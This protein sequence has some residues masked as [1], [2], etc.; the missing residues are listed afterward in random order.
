VLAGLTRPG[1]TERWPFLVEAVAVSRSRHFLALAALFVPGTTLAADPP[2]VDRYGDPIPVGAIARLGTIDRAPPSTN[3]GL[4]F[5]ADG[6]TF[7]AA[8][9][10]PAWAEWDA[11]TGKLLRRVRLPGIPGSWPWVSADGSVAVCER[12]GGIHRVVDIKTGKARFDLPK[13]A[14]FKHVTDPFSPDGRWLAGFDQPHDRKTPQHVRV[15]D[16]AT[17]KERDFGGQDEV[18]AEVRFS[19]DGSKLVAHGFGGATC[20]EVATGKQLW[21]RKPYALHDAPVRF[22]PDG[23]RVR[24]QRHT[25]HGGN[26]ETWDVATGRPADGVKPL[27]WHLWVI[28]YA[29]GGKVAFAGSQEGGQRTCGLWDLD[30]ERWLVRHPDVYLG[31]AGI[32]PDGKSFLTTYPRLQRWDVETLKP[33]YP[34]LADRGHL[35]V[36]THALYSPD[37]RRVYTAGA[38]DGVRAWEVPGGRP[39]WAAGPKKN[40]YS[41]LPRLA[42]SPDGS[43]LVLDHPNDRA[44]GASFHLIDPA[45]GRVERVVPYPNQAGTER[46]W[47]DRF[48]TPR[49][50]PGGTVRAAR[51]YLVRAPGR[52]VMDTAH[53][54]RDWDAAAGRLVRTN[55][56]QFTPQTTFV[57]DLAPD[58]RLVCS[59]R[60][61]CDAGTGRVMATLVGPG[62][63][64]A[65]GGA[66][67]AD[68][69]FV[70]VWM[71][72][73]DLP[74]S[75]PRPTAAAAW[76]WDTLT[77]RPVAKVR[78]GGELMRLTPDG[79][80]LLTANATG[81][82]A[83]DLVT[84]TQVVHHPSDPAGGYFEGNGHTYWIEPAPDGRTAVTARADQTCLVWDFSAAYRQAVTP[85]PADAD[86]EAAWASWAKP[87]ANPLAGLWRLADHPDR[88]VPF[89]KAKV[90]GLVKPTPGPT[91]DDIRRAVSELDADEFKTREAAERRLVEYGGPA[92]PVAAAALPKASPEARTR[93]GRV[94]AKLDAEPVPP[95]RPEDVPLAWAVAVLERVNSADARAVI[96]QVAAGPPGSRLT[97]EAN[98]ALDRVRE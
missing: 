9:Y 27:P 69:R 45:T 56:L 12:P 15:W 24:V 82:S 62:V 73:S 89:L 61:V 14:E 10:G 31:M 43:R 23:K 18:L 64:G 46:G 3:R 41:R 4:R 79:R 71:Y 58:G 44:E 84:G 63:A 8:L 75:G 98:A 96:E 28:G 92:R 86:L 70:A 93:L 32:F 77:G 72:T 36:V 40:G 25:Q 55:G 1:E 60:E 52:P 91:V 95:L 83:W 13:Y 59:G 51:S 33:L 2:R 38:V 34:D 29:P 66:F 37:G 39:L 80:F 78:V 35:A 21:Q 65:G 22:L 11:A 5:A 26:V 88:S 17:G 54:V 30:G 81:I 68:G 57:G 74:Y 42:L 6:K 49:L 16:T 7:H 47:G 76:V 97:R 50:L 67:S 20:W 48:G 87:D 90:A 19:P 53:E 94:L 85:P